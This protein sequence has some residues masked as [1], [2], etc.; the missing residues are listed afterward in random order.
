MSTEKLQKYL[1]HAGIAS[2]RACERIIAAGRV[3]VNGQVVTEKGMRV[4]PE[5]DVIEVDNKIVK[6]IDKKIY[7]LLNKPLGVITSAAD[8]LQR[9]TVLDLVQVKERI[10]PVGRLDYNTAGAL[11]LTNDGE[12]AYKLTHPS[13]GVWKK[14]LIE[15]N[16]RVS[17]KTVD[18]L[19]MGI[20][21][22]DGL[23]APARCRLLDAGSGKSKIEL[24]IHEGRNRQIRRMFNKLNIKISSLTRIEFG[25]IKLGDLAVGKWRY[26]TD[27]EKGMINQE[28][29]HNR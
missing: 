28:I 15:T 3:S 16:C 9:C 22:E 4:D 2:R 23:T 6:K 7:I 29:I 10:Y 14:Y 1:A 27:Y 26:L 24:S 17:Q 5:A 12:A 13:Q 8:E 19:A 21:L 18:L 11:L 20:E 25:P